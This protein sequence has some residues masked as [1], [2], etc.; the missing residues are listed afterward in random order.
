[1]YFEKCG[2]LRLHFLYEYL[3]A[4]EAIFDSVFAFSIRGPRGIVMV[5]CSKNNFV[6]AFQANGEL[7]KIL[8]FYRRSRQSLSSLAHRSGDL[9]NRSWSR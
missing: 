2:S 1:M 4:I 7:M 9:K 3:Y 8:R 6:F 5:F